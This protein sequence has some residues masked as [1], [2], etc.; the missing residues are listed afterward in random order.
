MKIT[1][2]NNNYKLNKLKKKSAEGATEDF[3]SFMSEPASSA[4]EA[5]QI[6]STSSTSGILPVNSLAMINGLDNDSFVKKENIDWGKDI[7]DEL[8]DL[9]GRI[10]SGNV[11]E[12][13]LHNISERLNNIPVETADESLKDL[14]EEIKTRA[15]V[16]L[17]KLERFRS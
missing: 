9:K 7:L 13:S 6:Q 10:L 1:E 16:E 4:T 17:A 5:S 8:N 12:K 15:V 14:V 3:S 2:T 11:T